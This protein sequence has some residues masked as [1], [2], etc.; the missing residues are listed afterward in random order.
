MKSYIL[1]VALQVRAPTSGVRTAG[2]VL[3]VGLQR[4]ALAVQDSLAFAVNSLRVCSPYF[5]CYDVVC[6]GFCCCCK[7]VAYSTHAGVLWKKIVKRICH[8][9]IPVVFKR[10]PRQDQS[11]KCTFLGYL[12]SLWQCSFLLEN[13]DNWAGLFQ[14]AGPTLPCDSRPCLNRGTCY[15]LG[16]RHFCA[17]P[18]GYEGDTCETCKSCRGVLCF[19]C[20]SCWST[21]RL[22]YTSTTHCCGVEATA[23]T[24]C[25][26]RIMASMKVNLRRKWEYTRA[27][28]SK[29]VYFYSCSRLWPSQCLHVKA[30]AHSL[31]VSIHLPCRHT[32]QECPLRQRWDMSSRHWGCPLAVPL[33]TG[34][35]WLHMLRE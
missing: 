22:F 28:Q 13:W 2:L 20:C 23:L 8:R 1:C 10:F 18:T 7:L 21:V 3:S 34:V 29:A 24:A 5:M 25:T 12:G 14:C 4:R 17:C 26:C 15:N 27:M 6:S 30:L 31:A 32:L 11:P 9:W 35:H 16:T 33:H 19:F